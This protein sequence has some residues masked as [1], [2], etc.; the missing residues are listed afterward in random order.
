MCIGRVSNR[1]YPVSV[2]LKRIPDWG[3]SLSIPDSNGAIG[4]S[5]DNVMPIGRVSNSVGSGAGSGDWS[6]V[7]SG[8]G[9]CNHRLGE[10]M[11]THSVRELVQHRSQQPVGSTTL[12]D[13][14]TLYRISL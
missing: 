11:G 7:G 12:R 6:Q 5:R 1:Q 14:V 10:L 2:P 4:G 13:L 3:T 9:S 8:Q